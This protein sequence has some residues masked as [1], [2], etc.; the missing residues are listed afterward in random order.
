MLRVKWL[1]MLPRLVAPA[2]A[3]FVGIIGIPASAG[4]EL[5]SPD[6]PAIAAPVVWSVVGAPLY[7]VRG[8]DERIHLAY[9]ILFTNVS[10]ASVEVESVEVIDPTQD[11]EATGVYE[12]VA[13]DGGDVTAQVKLFS[14][15][16]T[17]DAAD[18]STILPPGQSGLMFIDLT[19]EGRRSV[20]RLIAH[21]LTVSAPDVEESE[22]TVIGGF[23]KVSEMRA[24]VLKPPLR[25]DRWFNE[26]GCCDIIDAHRSTLL[27]LNGAPRPAQRFAIDFMQLDAEGR[28]FV[29]DGTVLSNWH[30]YGTDVLAAGAGKVVEVVNN[31]PN[32][33]P[34]Q[35][36]AGIPIEQAPGNHV[37]IDMGHDEFAMY[38][39]MIPGSVVVREGQFVRA[40]EKLGRLGN[41]GNTIVPHLHFQVMDRPSPLNSVGLPFVF[42]RMAL[43]G[44]LAGSSLEE[45]DDLLFAGG[46]VL[47]DDSVTGPR[48]RQMP[49]T[50]DML[51][52]R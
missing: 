23:E 51:G 25:G 15:P 42:D 40:G 28:V 27:P 35:F 31:L 49:L 46:A 9:E 48:R 10:P 52:F 5:D 16:G 24:V 34:G 37:I 17:L 43:Q 39:H 38:A 26:N 6:R 11:D 12:V 44:R 50:L 8:T 4:E 29:G 7:P 21:R 18:Y 3:A 19:F 32:Q 22:V 30:F 14:T 36:P 47:V 2:L 33:V 13:N 41:S 1:G 20:P 45:V